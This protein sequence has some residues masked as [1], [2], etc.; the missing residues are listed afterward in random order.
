MR[1]NNFS[2]RLIANGW[3]VKNGHEPISADLSYEEFASELRKVSA[4]GCVQ[5]AFL[6]RA[7]ACAY[8]RSFASMKRSEVTA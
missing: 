6:S 1:L 7:D 4:R 2:A 5:Q 3:L 8:I